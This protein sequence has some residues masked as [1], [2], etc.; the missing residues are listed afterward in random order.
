MILN[1]L[2]N[3][4]SIIGCLFA[5]MFIQELIKQIQKEYNKSKKRKAEKKVQINYNYKKTLRK[6]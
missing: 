4:F 2:R 6:K 3:V 1:T 5:L